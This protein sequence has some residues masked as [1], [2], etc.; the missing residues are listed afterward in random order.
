MQCCRD[1]TGGVNSD[2]IGQKT[3]ETRGIANTLLATITIL[4][5]KLKSDESAL[6]EAVKYLI[7]LV[8]EY[9]ILSSIND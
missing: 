5:I 3:P 8:Y 1:E 4:S 6:S 7:G 2:V 9:L